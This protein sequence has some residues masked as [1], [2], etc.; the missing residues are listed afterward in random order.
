MQ[1]LK[2]KLLLPEF[3]IGAEIWDKQKWDELNNSVD[4]EMMMSAL[5]GAGFLKWNLN[6]YQCFL[7]ESINGLN[8]KA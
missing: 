6:I 4:D 1:D 7:K 3:R 2:R 5:E 8:I